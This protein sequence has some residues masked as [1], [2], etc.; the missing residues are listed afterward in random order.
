MLATIQN[1]LFGSQMGKYLVIGGMAS[2][3]DVGV[4]VLLYEFVGFSAIASHSISIP[5]SA[6]YSFTCNA[7]LNF[8]KTDKLLLRFFS[9]SVVVF[10]GYLLGAAVILLVDDVMGFGGTIG[11]LASLPLVFFFQYFLNARISFRG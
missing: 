3:L 8:K 6:I 1:W 7:F 5:L 2:A 10:L 4:F 11:K 9:F